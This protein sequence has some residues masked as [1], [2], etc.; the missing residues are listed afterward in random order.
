M[1]VIFHDLQAYN[2]IDFELLSGGQD[3][4]NTRCTRHVKQ[5]R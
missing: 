2:C 4:I 5:E 1:V 3:G